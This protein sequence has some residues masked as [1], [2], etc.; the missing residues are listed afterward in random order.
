MIFS[1]RFFA[2]SPTRSIALATSPDDVIPL[3]EAADGAIDKLL[4]LHIR[5]LGRLVLAA[6]EVERALNLV[7]KDK[8]TVSA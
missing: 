7:P 1:A 4:T 6:E 8:E 2:W 5:V 3:L